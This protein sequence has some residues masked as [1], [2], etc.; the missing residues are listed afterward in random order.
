MFLALRSNHSPTNPLTQ[1]PAFI[2]QRY[3]Y[4]TDKSIEH[5]FLIPSWDSL[6]GFYDK[7]V[8]S[9]K[10][11]SLPEQQV[12]MLHME[13]ALLAD[14]VNKGLLG[15]TM[16]SLLIRNKF[17]HLPNLA[18]DFHEVQNTRQGK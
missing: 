4:A 13:F 3:D 2:T 14:R 8:A 5:L 1:R 9:S 15:K 7:I 17:S 6:R 16:R 10:A 12:F 18:A 11:E